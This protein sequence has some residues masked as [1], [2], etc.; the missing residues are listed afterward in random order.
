MLIITVIIS[1]LAIAIVYSLG[2]G[3]TYL[4]TKFIFYLA[5]A[6]GMGTAEPGVIFFIALVLFSFELFSSLLDNK[7]F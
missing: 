3:L 2:L 1:F 4:I 5:E 6:L 7:N